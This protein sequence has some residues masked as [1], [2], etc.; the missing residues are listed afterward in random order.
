[1]GTSPTLRE[2]GVWRLGL[3]KPQFASP[4]PFPLNGGGVGCPIWV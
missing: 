2:K 1:M 4:S 3:N